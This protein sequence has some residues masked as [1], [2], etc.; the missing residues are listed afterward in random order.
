MSAL[1]RL[2]LAG[3]AL[4]L[5]ATARADGTFITHP[6]GPDA[7]SRDE[8]KNI[9]LGTRAK[10]DSGTLVKLAVLSGGPTHESL[11][12]EFTARS[13]DQFD[14]YWKKQVFTGKGS[15]PEAMKSDAEMIAYV[16]ATAGAFGY[17]SAVPTGAAVKPIAI[18]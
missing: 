6:A 7:L 14:K 17:V 13:A 10:W 18:K 5:A 11:I 2:L 8:V 12:Q 3:L 1:S 16:S 15:A 9:L 4:A